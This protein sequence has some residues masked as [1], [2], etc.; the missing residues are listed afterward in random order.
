MLTRYIALVSEVPA[1]ILPFS[2]VAEVAAALA[3]QV[4]RDFAPIWGVSATVSS[5]QSQ[6]KVPPGYWKIVIQE[7]IGHNGYFGIHR[8]D[9]GQPF[10]LVEYRTQDPCW[11]I[12]A[13]HECLEMLAD[14]S[15]NELVEGSYTWG[16]QVIRVLYLVE[17][18][19]PCAAACYTVNGIQVS[20]FVTPR[21]FSPTANPAFGCSFQGTVTTPYS[22]AP[23]GYLTFQ[24]LDDESWWIELC[25]NQG[26][27][28]EQALA[29]NT[30]AARLGLR[31]A[32]DRQQRSALG[33]GRRAE[34]AD[35]RAPYTKEQAQKLIARR[36]RRQVARWK[37]TEKAA[38]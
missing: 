3:K 19:D 17:V 25:D 30:A 22:L 38:Q 8:L 9:N 31:S 32:I 14:H 33:R 1:S 10:A 18:C 12:Q 2:E 21:Y 4:T 11:T 26:T 37:R 13:S 20:D 7:E 23:S 15:L 34:A 6:A 29:P 16:G 36:A 35:E 24:R 27:W 5:Y 28:R